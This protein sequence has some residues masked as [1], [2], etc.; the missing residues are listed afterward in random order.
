MYFN[1][2]SCRTLNLIVDYIKKR[3]PE[4]LPAFLEEQENHFCKDEHQWIS[5][6]TANLLFR[7]VEELF[8]DDHIMV[9]IGRQA[10]MLDKLGILDN[11]VNLILE[12]AKIVA[13]SVNYSSLLTK[14]S[15][16]HLR[17]H[18]RQHGTVEVKMLPGYIKT[19]QACDLIKGMY[20]GLL[21][22]KA[23][24]WLDIQESEC[25]VPIWEKGVIDHC[26]FHYRRGRLW[27]EDLI[28][29]EWTDCGVLDSHGTYFYEGTLYGTQRC[30]YHLRWISPKKFWSTL[31]T[32]LPWTS[33]MLTDYRTR[34]IED[35]EIIDNQNQQLH[36]VNQKLQ[37]LLV[38]NR[39]LTQ[40]LEEK[41]RSRN[42]ELERSLQQLKELDVMKSYFLSITSHELR[43]P[44]TI[45]KGA[46]N[47]I[48]TEKD[49]MGPERYDKYMKMAQKNTERLILLLDDLLDLSRLEFGQLKL[50]LVQVDMVR[51]IRECLEEFRDEAVKKGLTLHSTLVDHSPHLMGDS[52][53][54]K[55][56]LNNLISNALKF[57]PEGG[58]IN[59]AMHVK[60]EVMEL[61][62]ADTGPG[63][64]EEEQKHVFDKFHQGNYTLTR[65]AG[66]I[67]LGLAIVKDLVELHSGR[68]WLTSHKQQG[69]CF[70]IQLPLAGP[71]NWAK[72]ALKK[73]N[74]NWSPP[75]VLKK[76][77]SK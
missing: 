62:V 6:Q 44:L 45:I 71:S 50:D 43:T 77:R 63:M 70:Y 9:A 73:V 24:T 22:K 61:S 64:D 36:H 67:G 4:I 65:Q 40:E 39:A 57:T 59:V 47:L 14:I 54:I 33:K 5:Y 74:E 18:S 68:L 26:R 8:D 35:Y 16:I 3:R 12:P 20:A 41:V 17:D 32:K 51:L 2:V 30:V 52:G 76:K 15:T 19:R 56:M 23:L 21:Q 66:G 13:L 31:L 60:E 72:V 7:K 37:E 10:Q 42:S 25:A 27:K 1:E 75:M 28:S 53:R 49:Q 58:T 34:L 11:I 38:A 48:D 29:K 69:S 46:L 55:Q